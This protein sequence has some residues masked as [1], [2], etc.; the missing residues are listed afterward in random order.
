MYRLLLPYHASTTSALYGAACAVRRRTAESRAAIGAAVLRQS[1]IV[2]DEA[3]PNFISPLNKYGCYARC[4]GIHI[5]HLQGGKTGCVWLSGELPNKPRTF[6]RT[7]WD[8]PRPGYITIVGSHT[9][10]PNL[11]PLRV[12]RDALCRI[13]RVARSADPRHE[14]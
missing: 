4:G 3:F 8:G 9:V 6:F 7:A 2:Y 1:G 10:G 11:S 13:C 14:A 5:R 12:R